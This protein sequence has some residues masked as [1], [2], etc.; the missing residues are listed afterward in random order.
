[1]AITT[2]V[3]RGNTV[4][5]YNGNKLLFTQQGNLH[6]YTAGSVA[7]KRSGIIYNYDEKGKLIST[8]NA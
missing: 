2:A 1:M 3:Q 5:V 7:V 8:H 4:F 6:G